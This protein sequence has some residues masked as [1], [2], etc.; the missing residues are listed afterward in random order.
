MEKIGR[1]LDREARLAILKLLDSGK[2]PEQVAAELGLPVEAVYKARAWG[3]HVKARWNPAAHR[4]AAQRSR[5]RI[6]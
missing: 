3:E 2:S 4:R 1:K 6:T 5:E